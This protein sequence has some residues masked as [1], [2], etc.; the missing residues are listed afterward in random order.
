MKPAITPIVSEGL[1]GARYLYPGGYLEY[2]ISNSGIRV[3]CDGEYADYKWE[4]VMKINSTKI[5]V[6]VYMY[7]N[8]LVK[9]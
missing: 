9:L 2:T 7:L 6:L 8:N 4:Q 1:K 3:A 5:N